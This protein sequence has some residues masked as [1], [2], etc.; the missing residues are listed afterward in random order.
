MHNQIARFNQ[1]IV[2]SRVFQEPKIYT[3]TY[4]NKNTNIPTSI[5]KRAKDSKFK[6][7]RR[8]GC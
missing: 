5:Q 3:H 7:P 6:T 8:K 2:Y 4:K 1:E